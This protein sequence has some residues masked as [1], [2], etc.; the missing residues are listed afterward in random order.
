M[1]EV[2]IHTVVECM[3][4]YYEVLYV[5][6]GNSLQV[7]TM[8]NIPTYTLVG[9]MLEEHFGRNYCFHK[10]KRVCIEPLPLC[11]TNACK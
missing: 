9:M 1:R 6:E 4:M 8:L 2:F 10:Q 5:P 3:Y 7:C 11:I